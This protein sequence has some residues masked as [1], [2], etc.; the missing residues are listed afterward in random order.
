[1]QFCESFLQD[2]MELQKNDETDLKKKRIMVKKTKR[3]CLTTAVSSDKKFLA[4]LDKITKKEKKKMD[5]AY[6]GDPTYQK[7]ATY[8]NMYE[9]L[10]DT[11]FLFS[12]GKMILED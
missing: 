10:N 1:M 3:Y 7:Y 12:I 8:N 2:L 5:A 6:A 11:D 4:S 9:R